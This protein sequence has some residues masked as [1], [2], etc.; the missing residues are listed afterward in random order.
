MVAQ[1]EEPRHHRA[2]VPREALPTRR[3]SFALPG[4]GLSM[5]DDLGKLLI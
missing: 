2:L 4:D 5:R 3:S 1:G